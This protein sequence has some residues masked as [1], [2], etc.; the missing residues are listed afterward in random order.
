MKALIAYPWPGNI[1]ELQNYLERAVV[2]SQ[3]DQLVTELLPNTVMGDAQAAQ[4]AV[5]RPTD[6][7]SLIREFVFNRLSKSE[8]DAEDLHKQIV[9]PVERE[10]L[11]QIMEACQQTQTKA[12]GR[13]GINRNTLYNKLVEFGLAKTNNTNEG[14]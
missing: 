4:A 10:L 12:A 14:E 11:L 1:R 7:H 9:E 6:D 5:F 13:L 2:G 8:A 3:S